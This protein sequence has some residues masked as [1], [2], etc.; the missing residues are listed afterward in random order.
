MVS[1]NILHSRSR[2]RGC[3]VRGARRGVA[4]EGVAAEDVGAEDMV[5][6]DMAADD[7]SEGGIA[8]NRSTSKL[9]KVKRPTIRHNG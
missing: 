7:S 1:A 2:R 3:F 9:M 4:A 5:I 6:R 8:V